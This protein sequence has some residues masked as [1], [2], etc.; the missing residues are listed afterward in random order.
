MFQ[1]YWINFSLL[2]NVIT[3]CPACILYTPVFSVHSKVF[4][5][6]NQIINWGFLRGLLPSC[7]SSCVLLGGFYEGFQRA[8]VKILQSKKGFPRGFP[9]NFHPP[10]N[11]HRQKN[12]VGF[13]GPS[14]RVSTG[15]SK[16]VP[17]RIQEHSIEIQCKKCNVFRLSKN[18]FPFIKI[19]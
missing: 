17:G 1:K 11:K 14:K 18:G 9:A 2:F 6:S 5:K 4:H 16:R 13:Q 10:S 8:S 3:L 15:A 12:M 19:N 7:V